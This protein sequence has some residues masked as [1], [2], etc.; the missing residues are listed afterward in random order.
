MFTKD[1]MVFFSSNDDLIGKIS[2]FL[3]NED[4]RRRI[5]KNGWEKVHRDL[6]ERLAAD[7]IVDVLFR[8]ELSHPYIWPTEQVI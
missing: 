4:G 1:E 8:E 7:F 3:E 2:H 6:N 5:A